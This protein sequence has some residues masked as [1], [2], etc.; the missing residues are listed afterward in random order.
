MDMGE[1]K[2]K[3]DV[4]KMPQIIATAFDDF[5]NSVKGTNYEFIA[6]LGNQLVNGENHAIIA[7]QIIE[8]NR[9]IVIILFNVVNS[10]VIAIAVER[11]ITTGNN[12][13]DYSIRIEKE[14]S[15]EVL[16]T[17]NKGRV[18]FVGYKFFLKALLAEQML[19][20][21]KKKYIIL[22][23]ADPLLP[24][25]NNVAALVYVTDERLKVAELLKNDEE[26]YENI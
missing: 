21:G 24:G 26:D 22:A 17:Y 14:I 23:E 3:I 18:G 16:D 1:W 5:K 7:E 4:D 11:L 12:L 25:A 2:I 9:N 6:Y 10:T 13:G 15:K 8:K 19:S 20:E